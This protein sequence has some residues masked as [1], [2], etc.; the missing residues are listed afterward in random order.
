ML[1]PGQILAIVGTAMVKFLF[2]PAWALQFEAKFTGIV[3]WCCVGGCLGV[4]VFYRASGWLMEAARRRSLKRIARTGKHPKTFTRFNRFVVRL[5]HMHGLFGIAAVLPFISIPVGSI[6][7]A[8]YFKHDRR[9]LP[10]LLGSVAVWS[11]LLSAF[12]SIGK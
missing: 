1:T 7:A 8:K 10:T 12:W 4:I 9:T 3:L 6:L 2:A 11:V 5:K